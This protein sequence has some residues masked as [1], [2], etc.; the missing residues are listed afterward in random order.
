MEIGGMIRDIQQEVQV[1][2]TSMGDGRDKVRDTEED[3]QRAQN[4]IAA[5]VEEV[6]HM[7]DFTFEIAHASEEQAATAQNISDQLQGISQR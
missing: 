7:R 5:I 2:I 3:F 6:N 4:A 1:N